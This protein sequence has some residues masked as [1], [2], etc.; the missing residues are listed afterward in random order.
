MDTGARDELPSWCAGIR[1]GRSLNRRTKYSVGRIAF[2]EAGI[3]RR[4]VEGQEHTVKRSI[5]SFALSSFA[6]HAM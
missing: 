4:A 6:R 5:L 3:Q 2:L 1:L